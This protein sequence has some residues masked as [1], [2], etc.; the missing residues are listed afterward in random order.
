[1]IVFS[2]KLTVMLSLLD[3]HR[4][5]DVEKAKS[6]SGYAFQIGYGVISWSSKKQ[7]V[8]SLSSTKAEYNAAT[9]CATQAVWLRQLMEV[10]HHEQK[11]PTTILCDNKSEI[12][13]S[14]NPVYHGRTKHI[15]VKFHYIRALVNDKVIEVQYCPTG[16]QIAYIFTKALKANKLSTLF[17]CFVFLFE[18]LKLNMIHLIKVG[19]IKICIKAYST[20]SSF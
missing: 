5:G 13:L 9:S 3:I 6:T 16:D 7:Q 2:I 20:S 11:I 8:V 4:A 1:M 14:K 19:K 15:N 12:A 18:N 17:A 10:L